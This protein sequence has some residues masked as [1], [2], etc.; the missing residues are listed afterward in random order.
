MTERTNKDVVT[1]AEVAGAMRVNRRTVDRWMK[2]GVLPSYKLPGGGVRIYR[3]D[4]DA[5]LTVVTPG[6]AATPSAGQP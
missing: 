3:A 4:L 2:A 6:L 1:I 5:L